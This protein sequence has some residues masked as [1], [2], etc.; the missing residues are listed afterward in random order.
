MEVDA[1]AVGRCTVHDIPHL[2]LRFPRKPDGAHYIF[3]IGVEPV[4]PVLPSVV[5][6][7]NRWERSFHVACVA[8]ERGLR[9]CHGC[10]DHRYLDGFE[11]VEMD[12]TRRDAL[13]TTY[14]PL[15]TVAT[16]L[17]VPYSTEDRHTE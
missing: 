11:V 14:P 8:S 5:A 10:G 2:K 12:N 16:G 13:R 4:T 7:R 1:L 6:F 9:I 17:G 15:S 3:T